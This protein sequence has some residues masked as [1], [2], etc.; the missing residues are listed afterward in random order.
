MR[1]LFLDDAPWRH[2]LVAAKLEGPDSKLAGIEVVHVW[3]VDECVEAMQTKGPFDE[4]YLDRDLNDFIS[5]TGKESRYASTYGT[6]ELTGRDVT[7]WMTKN[8]HL[9]ANGPKITVHSWNNSDAPNMVRD[10]QEAGLSAK[11]ELFNGGTAPEDEDF[12]PT[13]PSNGFDHG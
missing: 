2:N 12:D 10:L 13:A 6:G 11:W 1:I 7:R 9:F 5:V 3:T 4:I 8:L